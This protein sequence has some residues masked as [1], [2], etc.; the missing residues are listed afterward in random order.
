M[1][2]ALL[3]LFNDTG[4]NPNNGQLIA[5]THDVSLLDPKIFRRDQIWFTAKNSYGATDIFSLDEFDK[6]EV[7]KN[8]PFDKW[9]L[10]GRFGALPLID[11][12]RF[13]IDKKRK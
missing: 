12:N 4:K 11:K 9:Y 3:E 8:T 5:A 6:N 13:S 10:T 7:R 1:K 2:T